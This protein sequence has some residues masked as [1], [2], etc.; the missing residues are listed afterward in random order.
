MTTMCQELYKTLKKLEM[1]K[2]QTPVKGL[3]DIFLVGG[4]YVG[5]YII[6]CHLRQTSEF[7]NF[8]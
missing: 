7:R 5:T 3:S 6:N 1:K 2:P 4:G 8:Y